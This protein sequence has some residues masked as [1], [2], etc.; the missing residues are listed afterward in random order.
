V[1][2]RARRA[3][4]LVGVLVA[5]CLDGGPRPVGRHL[6]VGRDDEHVAF[7]DG[8][9]GKPRRVLLTRQ[10]MAADL[11]EIATADDPGPGGGGSQRRV[12]A[13]HV[14]LPQGSCGP[15]FCEVLVDAAGRMYLERVTIAPAGDPNMGTL[16]DVLL[17]VDP[18]T[19]E[20]HDF[21]FNPQLVVLS[22]D[23]TRVVVEPAF[24]GTVSPP[25]LRELDGREIALPLDV[26]QLQF[27]GNDLVFTEQAGGLSRLGAGRDAVETLLPDAVTMQ[28]ID[29]ARGWL[30][31]V[32]LLDPGDDTTSV[33]LVDA[34]TLAST[35][36]P[37][38]SAMASMF[39]PSPDGR[40]IATA[41]QVRDG[42]AVTLYDRDTQAETVAAVASVGVMSPVWRPAHDE[43]WLVASQFGAVDGVGG[44]DALLRLSPGG[45]AMR[46]AGS[47][48][49]PAGPVFEL[50]SPQKLDL[51]AAPAFTPDGRAYLVADSFKSA[52]EPAHLV[53]ADDPTDTFSV[54]PSGTGFAGAW[55]LPDG[56]LLVEDWITDD[57]RDDVYIVDPAARTSRA[58]ATSGHVVATGRDRILF[59]AHWVAAGGSGDLTTVD[60]ATGATTLIAENVSSV[61]VDP[62][63]SNDV[64]A[65][66][67]RVAYL[68]HNRI[69]A[70]YDGLWV[71]ELP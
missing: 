67:T 26:E 48:A 68:V 47:G 69:A 9:V 7:V 18:A 13:D 32:A 58:L 19:G 41:G 22:A 31:V 63:T 3:W 60:L 11:G 56:R 36:L 21:G 23:R 54:T 71:V 16:R 52:H 66:G 24:G 62:L 64:L 46:I 20:Q 17:S 4:L 2:R 15:S 55:P 61:A 34:Q 42:S 40:F 53:S 1:L 43:V 5:G 27:A 65:P 70:P 51:R 29:T 45:Q 35:T 38:T 59:L 57:L 14:S 37:P 12:V 28:A 6:F 50:T 8:P 49:A 10:Q 44:E 25:L 33:V 30:L 39:V